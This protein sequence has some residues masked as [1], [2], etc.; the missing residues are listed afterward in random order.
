MPWPD[1]DED[2]R[3]QRTERGLG[4]IGLMAVAIGLALLVYLAVNAV[5][6]GP[7]PQ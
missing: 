3:H 5:T 2:E 6:T 1:E 4:F 7:I